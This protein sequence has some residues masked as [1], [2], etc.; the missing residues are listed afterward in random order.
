MIRSRTYT[1]AEAAEILGISKFT[2]YGTIR[3]G[4]F[5]PRIRIIR[6]GNRILLNAADVD[7]LAGAAA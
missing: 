7:R 4:T 5:D 6:V 2:I 1:V 3:R